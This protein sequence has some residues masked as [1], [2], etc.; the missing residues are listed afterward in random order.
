MSTVKGGLEI[1]FDQAKKTSNSRTYHKQHCQENLTLASFASNPLSCL[2]K[3]TLAYIDMTFLS[4]EEFSHKRSRQHPEEN[5]LTFK[6]NW[7][8]T[9]WGTPG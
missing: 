9:E 4:F 1:T 6:L 3:I 5:T 2:V 8:P 7:C